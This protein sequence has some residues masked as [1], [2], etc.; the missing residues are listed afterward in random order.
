M[1]VE[2]LMAVR[3]DHEAIMLIN[4]SIIHLAIPIIL[5][6]MLT[7]LLKIIVMPDLMLIALHKANIYYQAN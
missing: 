3:G 6:T 2:Q 1:M 4:L 5:P 7:I